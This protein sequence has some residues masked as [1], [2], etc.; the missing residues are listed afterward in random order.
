M[1]IHPLTRLMET[2][3][4]L[5]IETR[6]EFSDAWGS[7]TRGLGQLRIML[8]ETAGSEQ[9]RL[10]EEWNTDLRDV[11]ANVLHFDDITRTYLLR[12][13]IDPS[14]LSR[15]A[16]LRAHFLSADNTRLSASHRLR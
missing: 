12:L 8:V 3:D 6:I 13:E 16:E 7:T 5:I 10:L 1:R 15:T 11:D 14:L 2:G 4:G 9:G